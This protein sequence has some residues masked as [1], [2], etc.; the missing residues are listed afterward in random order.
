[1]CRAPSLDAPHPH[2][3][4]SPGGRE[5]WVGQAPGQTKE[6]VTRGFWG[7]VLS[8]SPI[9]LFRPLAYG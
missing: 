5:G 6:V 7:L 3:M 1:M 4:V 8:V 9:G 2:Q